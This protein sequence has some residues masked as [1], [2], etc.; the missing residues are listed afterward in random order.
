MDQNT[1]STAASAKK[2]GGTFSW[3]L[4]GIAALVLVKTMGIFPTIAAIITYYGLKEKIGIVLSLLS[5]AV[6]AGAVFVG[7]AAYFVHSN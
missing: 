5:S 1:E 6:V 3:V 2:N 7:T 4:P